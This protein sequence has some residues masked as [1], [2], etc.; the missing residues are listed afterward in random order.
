M[1]HFGE[2][3]NGTF[4]HTWRSHDGDPDESV[5]FPSSTFGI[6]ANRTFEYAGLVVFSDIMVIFS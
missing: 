3:T 4:Q 6:D 1:A 2:Q 5:Y